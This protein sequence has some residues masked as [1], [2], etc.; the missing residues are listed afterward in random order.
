V[1]RGWRCVGAR[2]CVACVEP[3]YPV[4]FLTQGGSKLCLDHRRNSVPQ[5]IRFAQSGRVLPVCCPSPSPAADKAL[6]SSTCQSTCW[7]WWWRY[8]HC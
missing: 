4:F 7:D 8:S 6:L 5:A 3:R 2:V 1:S